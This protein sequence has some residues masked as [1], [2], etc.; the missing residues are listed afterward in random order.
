MITTTITSLVNA[1]DD[2]KVVP[3]IPTAQLVKSQYGR[4]DNVYDRYETQL[5][6]E[7]YAVANL[8]QTS[9]RERSCEPKYFDLVR[10]KTPGYKLAKKRGPLT[11]QSLRCPIPN[12][13]SRR[14]YFACMI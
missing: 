2:L 5:R 6:T 11:R 1:L 3:T 7:R 8:Q 14:T 4:T 13:L 12:P 10:R 9:D